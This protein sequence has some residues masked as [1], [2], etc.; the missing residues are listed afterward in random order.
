M[1]KGS[2]PRGNG[3]RFRR[4][5]R[6]SVKLKP[7]FSSLKGKLPTWGNTQGENVPSSITTPSP[8]LF[9][10]VVVVVLVA[11][12]S[13]LSY[14]R[15]CVCGSEERW[16]APEARY[17]SRL[18]PPWRTRST[19]RGTDVEA[20]WFTLSL[21]SSLFKYARP[22]SVNTAKEALVRVTEVCIVAPSLAAQSV[23]IGR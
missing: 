21:H 23:G 4:R 10:P 6:R 12:K 5:R 9:S 15:V 20:S 8:F 13:Y 3:A 17:D 1:E 7:I 16:L 2:R 22:Q 11:R 18:T 14:V 19:G